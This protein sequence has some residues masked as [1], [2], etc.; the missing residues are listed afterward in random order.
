L[1]QGALTGIMLDSRR[2]LAL[3]GNQWQSMAINGNQWQSD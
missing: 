3:N 1:E 2:G